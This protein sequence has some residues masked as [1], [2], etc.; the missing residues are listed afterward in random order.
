MLKRAIGPR[1]KLAARGDQLM[2][3]VP[4]AILFD[5]D[6]IVTSRPQLPRR[7]VVPGVLRAY[8]GA[9]WRVGRERDAALLKG[10]ESCLTLIA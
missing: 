3:H 6:D 5:L 8:N 4:R 9:A 7:W 10:G 2:K 1:T